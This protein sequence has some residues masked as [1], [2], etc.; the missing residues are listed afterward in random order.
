METVP[1][2]ISDPAPDAPG[3]GQM[4]DQ[5]PEIEGAFLARLGATERLAVQIDA[6]R[7][8]ELAVLPRLAQ[9]CGGDEHRRE[10]AG[11][12]GL[13]EAETLGQFAGDEIAQG[14]VVDQPD[15]TDVIERRLG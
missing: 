4:R 9:R 15:Q 3:L 14:H 1:E 8:V 10:M 13:D 6:Q 2:P 11:R 5:H 12:L 7:Q